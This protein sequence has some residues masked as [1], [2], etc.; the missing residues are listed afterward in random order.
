MRRNLR[1]TPRSSPEFESAE[2]TIARIFSDHENSGVGSEIADASTRLHALERLKFKQPA[3]TRRIAVANQ[4]GGVGKTSTTVNLAAALA[5]A[6]MNVLVIDMDPQGNAS[7]A[8]GAKHNSGDPSVYDVIE[9]ARASPTSCR[10]ALNSPR[11]RWSASIDLSG[12]ELEIS[13]LPNRNDLL[14]EALDKF[15]DESEI[16]Y[17]YVF[18]DC[19]PSLG[20]LVINAMCAVNEMLIPIQA[21]YYA[22]EGLGQLINTIGLVQTHFNPLLLVSTMLVT[23]FDKRTLLSREVYQEVK[24]HYPS[25]VLDTTIPRTVKI[26][27]APSFG[28]TVITYDPRGL[29][30]ISYREAAYEINERSQI[31]LETIASRRNEN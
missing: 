10:P 11:C 24:T 18:V 20:L 28:E 22:L 17:D 5:L 1:D 13:D 21:E 9:G 25:I 4:K 15:L 2:D 30:A 8:L 27:E 29:G 3:Q 14:D 12:A 16:H 6:G 31:V 19:A 7:T 26:S 23:M